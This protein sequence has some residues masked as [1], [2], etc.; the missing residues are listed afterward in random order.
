MLTNES[1]K[2][3]VS[4][5]HSGF[6]ITDLIPFLTRIKQQSLHPKELSYNLQV[7]SYLHWSVV[8]ECYFASKDGMSILPFFQKKGMGEKGIKE[9]K[10]NFK[11]ERKITNFM[12]RRAILRVWGFQS[13][14]LS[15]F[16]RVK[17]KIVK[18][19]LYLYD[20]T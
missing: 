4:N 11:G 8:R 13:F 17:Q 3:Y 10:G 16:L 15:I 20:N 6:K 14:S 1:G 2:T 5:D 19:N 7:S 18:K 12:F 9:L